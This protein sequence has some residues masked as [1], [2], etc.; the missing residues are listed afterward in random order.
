[1]A[2]SVV[3]AALVLSLAGCQPPTRGVDL[4]RLYG[5]WA[6]SWPRFSGS[7]DQ[8]GGCGLG[9]GGVSCG[10]TEAQFWELAPDESAGEAPG[11]VFGVEVGQALHT[12]ALS[13]PRGATSTVRRYSF[14]GPGFGEAR[15]DGMFVSSFLS[16]KDEYRDLVCSLTGPNT[17]VC[18][19]SGQWEGE[20]P[21]GE[22]T[23][24]RVDRTLMPVL[25]DRLLEEALLVSHV[26]LPG[27]GDP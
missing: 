24:Q 18:T 4:Q 2:G 8:A 3:V 27:L 11:D 20:G 16:R 13:W 17:L 21:V 10:W 5:S 15:D 7:P 6:M 12:C 22:Y 23:L 26:R 19:D 14:P 25:C 1:M 9:P